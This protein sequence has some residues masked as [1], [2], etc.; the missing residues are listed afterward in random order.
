MSSGSHVSL[1][2]TYEATTSI[3]SRIS[4]T[5]RNSSVQR[6]SMSGETWCAMCL[7]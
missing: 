6:R 3:G 2:R 4:N 1:L 7:A 5:L